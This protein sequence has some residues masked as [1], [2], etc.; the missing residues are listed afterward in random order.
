MKRKAAVDQ[1]KEHFP[2]GDIR[3]W[4]LDKPQYRVTILQR[5]QQPCVH[6]GCLAIYGTRY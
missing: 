4:Q 1:L 5:M 2:H 6:N 3:C